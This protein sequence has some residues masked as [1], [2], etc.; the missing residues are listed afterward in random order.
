MLRLTQGNRPDAGQTLFTYPDPLTITRQHLIT[1]GVYD[2]FTAKFDGLGRSIQTQ[3][4]TP[5]GTALADTAY[6]TVGHVAT[7]SNPYYQGSSHGSD[8][9]YGVTQTLYDALGRATTTTKQDGSITTVAYTGNCTTETDEAGK[10]RKACS[11]ALG[12]LTNVWEDPSGLNYETDYQYDTLGNLLRVDQKG[13]T[14]SDSTK[15]RTRLF[16]YNSLSQLLTAFNPESGTI[17]YVYDADGNMTSK[18]SPAPNQT[19]SA[20]VT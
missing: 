16:T 9:T 20:T 14:P 17:S 13:S 11:D 2:N 7:V 4:L 15:W 8:P 18:I 19:G 5:S 6:N 3:H 1:T 12:R 10:Q